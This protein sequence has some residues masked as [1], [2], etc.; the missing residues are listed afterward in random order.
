MWNSTL[1]IH[2]EYTL[3]TRNTYGTSIETRDLNN[4]AAES[5]NTQRDTREVSIQN[6]RVI[7]ARESKKAQNSCL[8]RVKKYFM[9]DYMG[10]DRWK[11]KKQELNICTIYLKFIFSW[12]IYLNEKILCL[13]VTLF[14][15]L[16]FEENTRNYYEESIFSTKKLGKYEHFLS[17]WARKFF[18]NH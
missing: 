1:C 9:I 15:F 2:D 5:R 16:R 11:E 4:S 8:L 3:L 18:R 14:A 12:I 6:P 10:V 7:K 17:K 13:R